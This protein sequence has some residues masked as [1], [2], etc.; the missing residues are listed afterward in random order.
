ME[1]RDFQDSNRE[2]QA[3]KPADDAIIVDT[4][5]KSLLQVINDIKNIVEERV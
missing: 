1:Q 4:T 3:S 5:N 2:I